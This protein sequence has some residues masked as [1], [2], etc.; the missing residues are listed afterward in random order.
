ML[1]ISD[2]K[3]ETLS[4]LQI[5]CDLSYAWVIIDHYTMF[6]QDGIKKHPKLVG[7]LRCTFLKLASALDIPLL[8][9]NQVICF[10]LLLYFDKFILNIYLSYFEY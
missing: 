9:I 7:C 1:Q 10:F 4:D 5:I 8:R 6:M 2:F 3:E